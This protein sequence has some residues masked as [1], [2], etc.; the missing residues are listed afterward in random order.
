MARKLLRLALPVFAFLLAVLTGWGLSSWREYFA[1]GARAGV[2]LI[3]VFAAGIVLLQNLD[4]YIL[5]LGKSKLG[6]QSWVLLTLTVASVG[7]LWF[8]PF[9]D[10]R[11]IL[12][13]HHPQIWRWMGLT[14]CALGVAVRLLAL[15]KL[16]KQ[17]SAYVTIQ[18]GHELVQSGIYGVIRHPL[19]LSLL[20]AGPGFALVFRSLLIW[21]IL[22]V[23]LVFISVRIRQEERLLATEF[24]D[25][26]AR[27]HARTWALVPC[28]L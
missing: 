27:Y 9:A 22:A 26:F 19:Y 6:S 8:F 4:I 14:L 13:L 7:L 25:A 12:T 17:F 18:E 20:L 21:P 15:G 16:G 2:M 3:A 23:T 1:D 5:R 11:Q 10:R 28:I 24:G